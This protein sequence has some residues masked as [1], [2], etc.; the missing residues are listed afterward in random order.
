MLGVLADVV[1]D[2]ETVRIANANRVRQLTRTAADKDGEERG[3]GLTADHPEVAKLMATVRALEAAEHDAI[4]NLQRALRKHPLAAFQKRHKGVGEKQLARLLAVIGDPYWNDLYERPRTVSELWAYCGLHV[5]K[6]SGG[7][8]S[9][10]PQ[11]IGAAGAPPHTGGQHLF[12]TQVVHA[13]G[14]APKRQRGQQ[15]NWSEIARKRVWVIASA[16]PKF[17]GGHYEQVYRTAREKYADATHPV[18]CVRCGPAGKPAP[19]GSPL[20][21]GHKH[22]RAIRITA[23]EILKDLWIEARTA[24]GRHGHT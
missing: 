8:G 20:S 2:L 14:V 15:A 5:V 18:D 6:T 22:A 23:K 3:F 16:M 1:D 9:R 4:L 7:Q 12:G 24:P 17:P 10:E 21:D 11:S 13:P 19:A